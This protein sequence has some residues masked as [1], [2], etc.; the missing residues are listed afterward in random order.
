[1]SEKTRLEAERARR[2][3]IL[4]AMDEAG[5][6]ICQDDYEWS[7]MDGP[8]FGDRAQYQGY[9]TALEQEVGEQTM[10]YLTRHWERVLE[11]EGE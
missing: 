10:E 11:G 4:R 6:D 2:Q 3:Q 1:M 9:E 7:A 5:Q 8:Y